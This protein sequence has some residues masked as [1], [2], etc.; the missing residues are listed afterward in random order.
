MRAKG[1][2][3][4]PD[5]SCWQKLRPELATRVKKI[6]ANSR[7]RALLDPRTLCRSLRLYKRKP[8]HTEHTPFRGTE[9]RSPVFINR[10]R[11]RQ[12]TTRYWRHMSTLAYGHPHTEEF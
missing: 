12:I 10:S 8:V 3:P 2:F 7:Y 1:S 11:L 4:A 9:P 6:H 5:G